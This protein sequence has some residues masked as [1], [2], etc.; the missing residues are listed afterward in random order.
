MAIRI[1][2]DHG[3]PEDHIIFIT[4]LASSQGLHALGRVFPK[5]KVVVGGLDETMAGEG[6]ILSGRWLGV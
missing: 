5:V 3:V 6:S 1:L 4:I 2:L